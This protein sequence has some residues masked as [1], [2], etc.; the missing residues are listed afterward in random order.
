MNTPHIEKKTRIL[1]DMDGTITDFEGELFKRYQEKYPDSCNIIPIKNRKTFYAADDYSNRFGPEYKTIINDIIHEKGFFLSLP[2]ITG[3]SEA[4]NN[5]IEKGYDVFLCTSPLQK[6][7]NCVLEKYEWV[8]N[9]LGDEWINR[10]ILTRDKTIIKGTILI[11]DKPE[12]KGSVIPKWKHI[13]FHQPYNSNI[14]KPR[15]KIWSDWQTAV[16]SPINQ[17]NLI[18]DKSNCLT[19][20]SDTGLEFYIKKHDIQRFKEMAPTIGTFITADIE[21]KINNSALIIRLDFINN[22]TLYFLTQLLEDCSFDF[23]VEIMKKMNSEQMEKLKKQ[24]IFLKSLPLNKLIEAASL[25]NFRVSVD[26]VIPGIIT[27]NSVKS[28]KKLN[29]IFMRHGESEHNLLDIYNADPNFYPMNLTEL[30]K[31]QSE[32][33]AHN[34]K[35]LTEKENLTINKIFYSPL[36]RAKQSAFIV[37]NI[38]GISSNNIEE[39]WQITEGKMGRLEGQHFGAFAFQHRACFGG[40]TEEDII[41]R[42]KSFLAYVGMQ[43]H[44]TILVVSHSCFCRIF[45]EMCGIKLERRLEN[46]EFIIVKNIYN[47]TENN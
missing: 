27:L 7:Q 15:I 18:V 17:K 39:S 40:E 11:D 30:G 12:I 16:F 42:I 3:A 19:L 45:L 44:T 9:N 2:I 1:V 29:I 6:F 47:M 5:M 28:E 33:T 22:Q 10:I 41:I 13:L 14:N 31:T 4:L 46:G 38:V 43:N 21:K 25:N 24:T 26:N 20:I 34:I 35:L 23:L 8:K 37:A 32:N 36:P